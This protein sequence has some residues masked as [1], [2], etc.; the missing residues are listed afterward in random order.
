MIAL[1]TLY[2][3]KENGDIIRIS[4]SMDIHIELWNATTYS[5]HNFKSLRPGY[6]RQ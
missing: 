2:L 3:T 4:L 6:V 1:H 5:Y